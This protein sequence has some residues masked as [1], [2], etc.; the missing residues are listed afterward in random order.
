[1]GEA[2]GR[3]LYPHQE[4]AILELLSGANV[5]LATPTGS[6]KSLRWRSPPTPGRSAAA[7]AAGTRHRSR[8]SCRRSSSTPAASWARERRSADRRLGGQ[9][10]APVL[11][12]TTE[13]LAHVVLRDGARPTSRPSCSTSSTTTAI[14]TGAGRGRW[15]AAPPPGLVPADVGDPRRRRLLPGEELTRRTGRPTAIVDDAVRPVPLRYEYRRTL[16]HHTVEGPA[17]RRRRAPYIVNPSQK[18]AVAQACAGLGHQARRR[19]QGDRRRGAGPGQAARRLRPRPRPAPAARRRRAPR[20]MLPATAAWWSALTQRGRLRSISGT[21][22]LGVGVN[23]P[24]RTV[25]LTR[26]LASTTAPRAACSPPEFHQTSAARPG[27]NYDTEGP[28]SP[29]P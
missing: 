17:R 26:L 18:D 11:C 9:P 12:A 3:P 7:G 5:I 24:I 14:P 1:M 19:G 29:R 25:V 6:G 27:G 21:D 8:R 16:L 23:L 4:E 2:T 20:R 10:D 13:I 28:S 22:T 15:C